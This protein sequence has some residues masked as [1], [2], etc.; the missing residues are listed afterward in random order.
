MWMPKLA[1]LVCLVYMQRG[2]ISVALFS[3]IARCF[4]E[5]CPLYS[6][7]DVKIVESGQLE[8]QQHRFHFSCLWPPCV[9]DADIIF[10]LC[11]FYLVLSS[12]FVF[13]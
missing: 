5:Q 2:K 3:V 12:I 11:D 10:L 9:A 13:A 4:I 1:E 7:N 8:R 6:L